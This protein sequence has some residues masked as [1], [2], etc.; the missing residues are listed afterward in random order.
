[1]IFLIIL[2]VVFVILR[3]TFVLVILL[4]SVAF[5]RSL[6]EPNRICMRKLI[7]CAAAA[8]LLY[9]QQVTAMS[10]FKPKDVCVF[11]AV[12]GVL[13]RDGEPLAGVEVLRWGSWKTEFNDTSITDDEG[14]FSFPDIYQNSLRSVLPV[15]FTASQTM[16]VVVDGEE[17]YFWINAKR[18]PEQNAEL[19]GRDIDVVCDLSSEMEGTHTDTGSLVTK[20]RWENAS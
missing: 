12:K 11:S 9:A 17:D 2:S 19:N 20:C 7:M 3:H 1:M 5:S 4:R 10:I 6:M 13:L 16:K 14:R 8:A 15:E 18:E